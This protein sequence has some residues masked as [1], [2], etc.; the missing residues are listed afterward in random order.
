MSRLVLSCLQLRNRSLQIEI[1]LIMRRPSQ[2]SLCATC[3]VDA[4]HD[5]RSGCGFHRS[6]A[7]ARDHPG[8]G[9]G[10]CG[11]LFDKS[12]DESMGR[13]ERLPVSQPHTEIFGREDNLLIS[14]V[15]QVSSRSV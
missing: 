1:E 3:K 9:D 6:F 13:R 2:L 4:V 5:L 7:K 15:L 12:V 11:V 10:G 14:N 8:W